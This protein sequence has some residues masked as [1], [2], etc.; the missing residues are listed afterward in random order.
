MKKTFIA[1][2]TFLINTL[3]FG[4]VGINTQTPMATL[5]IVASPSDLTKIDGIIAPRITGDQL[6]AKDTLYTKT[7]ST[8]AGQTGVIIYVTDAITGSPSEKTINITEAGYYYFN[9][10][11]WKKLSDSGSSGSS[12]SNSSPGAVKIRVNQTGFLTLSGTQSFGLLAQNQGVTINPEY[13]TGVYPGGVTT[14]SPTDII[15]TTTGSNGYA[16]LE[17][18]INGNGNTYRLNMEYVMGN[19][20]PSESKYFNVRVESIGSGAM[21]YENSIVVP[22]RLDTGHVAPFQVMFTTIAD[23]ASI[24]VGYRIIF[25][26]DTAASTGLQNNIGVRMVDIARIN[27]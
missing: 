10:T 7:T 16:L 12:Y 3:S 26:V 14:G 8:N 24:G 2:S 23:S 9:G 1:L 11:V 25:R 4:Q 19:N 20:P 21:I 22:G 27:Q 15:T 6:K 18:P 5:D 13:V 17:A